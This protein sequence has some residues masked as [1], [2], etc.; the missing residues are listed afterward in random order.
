MPFVGNEKCGR[1]M[2]SPEIPATTIGGQDDADQG[3][4]VRVGE[5]PKLLPSEKEDCCSAAEGISKVAEKDS[6]GKA[7][8]SKDASIQLVGSARAVNLA[9]PK[10][11]G[12]PD[13]SSNFGAAKMIALNALALSVEGL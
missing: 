7:G 11:R 2:H 5:R 13:S 8:E 12:G 9:S 6:A 4:I 3:A 10:V 1:E